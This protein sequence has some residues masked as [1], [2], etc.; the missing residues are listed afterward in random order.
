MFLLSE[1]IDTPGRLELAF[2]T[3]DIEELRILLNKLDARSAS[4]ISIKM[5]DIVTNAEVFFD[6]RERP[7]KV[8]LFWLSVM[9][10]ESSVHKHA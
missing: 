5:N 1:Y 4:R 8:Q 6:Y 7:S 2:S 9:C 10:V 3:E